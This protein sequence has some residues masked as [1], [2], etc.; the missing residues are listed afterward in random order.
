MAMGLPPGDKPVD[1]N[2]ALWHRVE[3]TDPSHTR[4]V[5]IGRKL[6]AIDSYYQIKRCTEQFGA[7]GDG[8]GYTL[9][10]KIVTVGTDTMAVV[11]MVFW[12]RKDAERV[13]CAPIIA[14][15]KL[16]SAAGKV[17]EE[18]FKKAITDALT[19]SLSYLGFSAD[20]FMGR[21]DD[22]RYVAELK[23]K[24]RVVEKKQEDQIKLSA[25]LQA[26]V[27]AVKLVKDQDG[28]TKLKAGIKAEFL[29]LPEG[30]PRK[31][32][33]LQFR[34]KELDLWPEMA[35]PASDEERADQAA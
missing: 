32:V 11:K 30:A 1:G 9:E 26:A 6:T 24:G 13:A 19:K 35:E 4:E 22:N 20:V 18:A 31:Y 7:F 28:F 3:E 8:W 14:M 23:A 10:D 16:V 25:T 12:Y 21:Y 5:T 17:D 15:N 27:E 29:K 33:A 2:L 34:K